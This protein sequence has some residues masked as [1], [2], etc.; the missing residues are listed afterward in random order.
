MA[1][2]YKKGTGTKRSLVGEEIYEEFSSKFW[3]NPGIYFGRK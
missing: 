1:E 3:L 2:K